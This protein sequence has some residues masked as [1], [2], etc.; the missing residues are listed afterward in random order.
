[1]LCYALTPTGT[2]TRQQP[3][4]ALGVY[5]EQVLGGGVDK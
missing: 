5:S 2:L 3:L 1:M 4:K